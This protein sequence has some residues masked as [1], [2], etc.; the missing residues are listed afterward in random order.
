MRI[1]KTTKFN[2]YIKNRWGKEGGWEQGEATISPQVYNIISLP[3]P[4][5]PSA[6]AY[7][8][9]H[10]PNQIPVKAFLPAPEDPAGVTFKTLNLLVLDNGLNIRKTKSTTNRNENAAHRPNYIHK[11]VV[12]R[13][14]ACKVYDLHCPIVTWSP[15][16]TRK[17]GD[18]CAG[19]FECLFSYLKPPTKK[20]KISE[21]QKTWCPFFPQNDSRNYIERQQMNTRIMPLVFLDVM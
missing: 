8:K 7:H 5:M 4:K 11:E 15:S 20:K 12:K 17:H 14:R 18:T 21:Q 16:F 1:F 13:R 2:H 19:M 10:I 3:K 9:N 6:Q